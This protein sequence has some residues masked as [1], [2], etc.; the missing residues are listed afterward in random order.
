MISTAHDFDASDD[1]KLI[2]E[3]V[4]GAGSIARQYYGQKFEVWEKTKDNPVTEAD[5]AI[6]KYL[7]ERLRNARPGYGWLSEETADDSSRL[8]A[9]CTF[10]VDPIDGTLAFVRNKPHFTICA[11]AARDGRPF[12]G[13]V[14]N[15]ISE[16]CFSAAAGRGAF[17]NGAAIAPSTRSEVENCRMLA[18]KGM[19][20]H[21][22]WS[23][24]PNRPWPPMHIESRSSIA[25]RMAL[26]ACGAFDAMLALSSKHD[27]D[28]AAADIILTEA[29]ARV[30]AHSGDVLLYNRQAPL[31][32]SVVAAGPLLHQALMERVSHLKLPESRQ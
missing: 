8:S 13:V 32:P 16:E 21:P 9:K 10:I 1:Q 7:T 5:L 11:A 25:Y 6:D 29:G 2:E 28:L 20:N 27:W 3:A 22:A 17:L 19:L 14:Y 18:D 26:V 4:R 24:P 30:T 12:A 31:Q 15:P 23:N